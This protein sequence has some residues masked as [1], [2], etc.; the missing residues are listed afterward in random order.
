MPRGSLYKILHDKNLELSWD[1]RL[2]ICLDV[3]HG[4]DYLHNSD[5]MIIHRDLKV[6]FSS[7]FNIL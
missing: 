2:K 6:F 4:V 3:S 5:P 1:L 7:I